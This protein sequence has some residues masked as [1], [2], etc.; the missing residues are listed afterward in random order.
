[1]EVWFNATSADMEAALAVCLLAHNSFIPEL[2][3]SGLRPLSAILNTRKLDL[4][5]SSDEGRETS[6]LFHP[7]ESHCT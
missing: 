2:L 5:P 7:L 6:T 3:V 1:V 4:F